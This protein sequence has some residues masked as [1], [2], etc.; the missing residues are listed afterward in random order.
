[1]SAD[2][3]Y[4]G[5]LA[6]RIL[7][8]EITQIMLNA[9][10][11]IP[12]DPNSY[13]PVVEGEI[14]F[15]DETYPNYERTTLDFMKE[16]IYALQKADIYVELLSKVLSGDEGEDDLVTVLNEK[17]TEFNQKKPNGKY[18]FEENRVTFDNEFGRYI[19]DEQDFE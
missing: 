5:Q 3:L 1:M 16:A 6:I 7:V 8:D 13:W 19:I 4:K 12:Y 14:R 18:A 2:F 10:R 11:P 17:L 15:R 9:G